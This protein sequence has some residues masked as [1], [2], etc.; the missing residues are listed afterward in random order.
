MAYQ[1]AT[2]K[3]TGALYVV[4][5]YEGRVSRVIRKCADRG[6]ADQLLRDLAGWVL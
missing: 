6:A 4:L 5:A 1:I 2:H 3:V